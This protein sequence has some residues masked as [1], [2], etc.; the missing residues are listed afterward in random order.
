MLEKDDQMIRDQ[1]ENHSSPAPADMWQRIKGKDDK[2][3]KALL[4]WKWYFLGPAF[5]AL[6]LVGVKLFFHP[7]IGIHPTASATLV[8]PTV[9]TAPA[10]TTTAAGLAT[11]ASNGGAR[12]RMQS[13]QNAYSP[14]ALTAPPLAIGTIPAGTPP[15]NSVH[16]SSGTPAIASRPTVSQPDRIGHASTQRPAFM[17]KNPFVEK[18]EVAG[19]FLGLRFTHKSSGQ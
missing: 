3:R 15:L 8:A 10:K 18:I 12:P 4:F 11:P 13:M 19:I 6:S 5:L 17:F 14:A 9:P 16:H 1:F 7:T 2:D